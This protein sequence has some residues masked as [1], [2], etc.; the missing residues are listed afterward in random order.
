MEPTTAGE[1]ARLAKT[2]DSSDGLSS[3]N[4]LARRLI[5]HVEE[6]EGVKRHLLDRLAI[7]DDGGAAEDHVTSLKAELEKARERY[8]A[9]LEV[10]EDPATCTCTFYDLG[11]L[12]PPPNCPRCKALKGAVLA[13]EVKP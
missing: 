8:A 12:E 10:L 11:E 5:A 13:T 6:L 4:R 2:L 3:R 7:I 9:L 1:R